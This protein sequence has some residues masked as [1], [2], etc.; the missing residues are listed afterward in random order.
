[1]FSFEENREY[2]ESLRVV[3]EMLE[4]AGSAAG[5]AAEELRA[6]EP[7]LARVAARQRAAAPRLGLCACLS[8]DLEALL[9]RIDPEVLRRILSEPTAV[10]ETRK[11]YAAA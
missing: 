9:E 3:R 10:I 2:R 11:G 8:P 4:R 7:H 5:V 1:M 6:R